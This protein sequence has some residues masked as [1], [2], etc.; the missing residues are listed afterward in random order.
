MSAAAKRTDDGSSDS[1]NDTSKIIRLFVNR[2]DSLKST[3]ENIAQWLESV[4]T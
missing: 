2:Q 4:R 1:N 3:V